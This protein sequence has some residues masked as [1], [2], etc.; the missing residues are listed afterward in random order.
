MLNLLIDS[1]KSTIRDILPI[2]LVI[3]FF[4]IV[5][6][7]KKIPNLNQIAAGF[8]MVIVGLS[9]FLFGLEK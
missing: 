6:L 9:I 8:M 7:R 1:F 4:Q 3:A 2:I 5:A